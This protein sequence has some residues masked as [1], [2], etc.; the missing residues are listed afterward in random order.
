MAQMAHLNKGASAIMDRLTAGLNGEARTIDNNKPGSAIMAVHVEQIADIS[1]SPNG[2]I[3]SIS[4]YYKQNGDMMADPDMTF[5]RGITGA[6]FPLTF[7]QDGGLPIYQEVIAD[8]FDD[9][10]I[11]SF[12]PKLSRELATFANMWMKNIKSQQRL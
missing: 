5:L 10:R 1:T 3:Y 11:K 4:H 12:R 7:Q 2:P 8:R 9:G 6:W